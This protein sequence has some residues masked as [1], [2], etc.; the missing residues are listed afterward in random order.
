MLPAAYPPE[1]T[2]PERPPYNP[3]AAP[4][5]PA[6]R[7]AKGARSLGVHWKWAYLGISLVMIA[8]LV[9]IYFSATIGLSPALV[10]TMTWVLSGPIGIGRGVFALMWISAAWSGLP[11]RW[12]GGMTPGRAVGLL[13]VPVYGFYWIFAMNLRLW[14]RLDDGLR[15]GGDPRHAPRAQSVAAAV[16]SLATTVVGL[17]VGVAP[18]VPGIGIATTTAATAGWFVY[19]LACDPIR[20]GV[21]EIGARLPD[22]P[23]A[24]APA[25][26]SSIKLGCVLPLGFL[27]LLL[28]LA[29]WQFLQPG[30]PH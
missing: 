17:A 9:A 8:G 25:R 20:A 13:F 2:A 23:S 7:G 6:M 26:A 24:P 18:R 29:I 12:R 19:M 22:D 11:A 15:A 1:M 21:A 10:H 30:S 4:S 3:Y 14:A 28:L 16:I 27:L 5:A